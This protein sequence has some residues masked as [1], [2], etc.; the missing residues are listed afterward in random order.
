METEF[1][2]LGSSFEKYNSK[3]RSRSLLHNGRMRSEN[4]GE[5]SDDSKVL[6]PLKDE[7]G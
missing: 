5:G 7:L 2:R 6:A 4:Y 1:K 3:K